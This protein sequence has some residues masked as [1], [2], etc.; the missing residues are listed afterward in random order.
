MSHH[1]KIKVGVELAILLGSAPFYL[2]MMKYAA[3]QLFLHVTEL[4]L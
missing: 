1:R 2:L 4:F 3:I